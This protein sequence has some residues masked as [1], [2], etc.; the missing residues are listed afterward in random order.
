MRIIYLLSVILFIISGCEL[1]LGR[2]ELDT[3]FPGDKARISQLIH[4]QENDPDNK[5]LKKNLKIMVEE[6]R[7]KR[8]IRDELNTFLTKD[9]KYIR[10]LLYKIDNEP[11]D[12][13]SIDKLV[14]AVANARHIR[15]ELNT[16]MQGDADYIRQLIQQAEDNPNNLELK[17]KLNA[18]YRD[19]RNRRDEA[20]RRNNEEAAMER[21]HREREDN[22]SIREYKRSMDKYYMTKYIIY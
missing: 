2:D 3:F 20:I 18:A 17:E 7:V 16:F 8:N 14:T 22:K 12:Q 19:A 1:P 15:N 13:T 6:A 21:R 9:A 11:N 5:E 10:Q 4:L